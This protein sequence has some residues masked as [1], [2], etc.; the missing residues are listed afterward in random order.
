MDIERVTAIEASPAAVWDLLIDPAR[1]QE[2]APEVISYDTDDKEPAVGT[3]STMKIKEG[4][5]EI[6]YVTEILEYEAVEHM[7][8]EMRGGSLGPT[9]MRITYD[10][11]PS[12]AGTTLTYRSE[13]RAGTLFLKLIAPLI[14]FMAGRNATQAMARLGAVA[15]KSGA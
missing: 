10:V 2:W 7:V 8:I 1:V 9:P 13:W 4:S 11:A 6:A 3:I 15:S 14:T 5:K 12:G